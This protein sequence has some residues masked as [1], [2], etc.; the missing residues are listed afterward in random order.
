MNNV[1]YLSRGARKLACIA[2]LAAALVGIAAMPLKADPTE[3]LS[4]KANELFKGKTLAFLPQTLGSPAFDTWNYVLEREAKAAGFN[5]VVKDAGW[6]SGSLSQALE[7]L[8]ADHPDVLVVNPPNV[9]LLSRQVK[10]AMDQGIIVISLG[11][12]SNEPG[13]ALVGG[14]WVEQ[15]RTTAEDM[16]KECGTNSGKSGKIALLQGMVTSSQNI[17]M[18][19]VMTE[20]LKKDPAIKIVSTQATDWEAQKAFDITSAVLQQ[21]PDLCAAYNSYDVTALGIGQAV[22]KAGL[23]GKVLVYS[24][25]G[26]YEIG[27]NAVRDGLFDKYWNW[28]AWGEARSVISIAK[29]LITLQVKPGDHPTIPAFSSYQII[30]KDNL[31]SSR[32]SR[33]PAK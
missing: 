14:D 26:G 9:Q 25:G 7:G 23:S 6:N 18:M 24:N 17:S 27:C 5:Y 19:N 30:T 16:L 15:A 13:D 1:H 11:L 3:D 20:V 28:D 4:T 31:E 21:H 12:V 8:I 22:K 2:S 33:L 10:K 29:T 32:C